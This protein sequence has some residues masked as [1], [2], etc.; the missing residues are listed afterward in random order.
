MLTWKCFFCLFKHGATV[1]FTLLEA[2]YTV[3]HLELKIKVKFEFIFIMQIPGFQGRV[4]RLSV[5]HH[6]EIIIC[7]CTLQT[8]SIIFPHRYLA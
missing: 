6:Y 2:T 3:P 7:V 1:H 5:K 8:F 4:F